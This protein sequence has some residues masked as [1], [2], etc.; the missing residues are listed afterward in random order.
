VGYWVGSDERKHCISSL[1]NDSVK[2][3]RNKPRSTIRRRGRRGKRDRCLDN[4][5]GGIFLIT[6]YDMWEDCKDDTG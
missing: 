3:R 6:W 5:K 1:G 4:E 2:I